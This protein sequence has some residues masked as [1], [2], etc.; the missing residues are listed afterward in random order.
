M[1][2]GRNELRVEDLLDEA[3][4]LEPNK[5]QPIVLQGQF[6]FQQGQ[7]KKAVEV[8]DKAVSLF[9]KPGAP[10]YAGLLDDSPLEL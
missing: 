5:T 8:L 4:K 9:D 10:G 3:I 6:L 2:I 7:H 1:I